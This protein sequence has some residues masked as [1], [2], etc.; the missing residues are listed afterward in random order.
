MPP[1]PRV[2]PA[3][4]TGYVPAVAIQKGCFWIRG[5]LALI[6]CSKCKN[7]QSFAFGFQAEAVTNTHAIEAGKGMGWLMMP[8][9]LC[10]FC[11]DQPTKI[12]NPN[13]SERKHEN[14]R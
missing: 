1:P 14:T 13:Y 9:V 6:I 10:R 12:T 11:H 5:R 2:K 8:K 3:G 7:E 4:H